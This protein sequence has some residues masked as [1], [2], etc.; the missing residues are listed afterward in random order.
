MRPSAARLHGK[1][2]VLALQ[3]GGALGAYQAGVY[4]VLAE[5]S[6][7]PDWVVGISIG[8]VN[9]AIIAGNP[10]EKRLSHL[11][12]FWERVSSGFDGQTLIPGDAARQVMDGWSAAAATLFG[13]SGFFAPRIP[14]PWWYLPGAPQ[15]MS[16]YDTTPLRE[17]L[18]E[19][20][21]FDRIN[22]GEMRFSVGAVNVR[23]G[24]F[25][26]FD[27][28]RDTIGPEHVMASGALPP[29]FP[30]VRIDGEFYW[31]GGVVT[32]TPLAYVLSSPARERENPLI[33]QVDLFSAIGQ[34]P[35][36]LPEVMERHKDILYSSRTRYITDTFRELHTLRW[37][38]Q[39]VL[40]KLPTELD[41]DPE[42]MR[43]KKLSTYYPVTV[44]HL[45]YRSKNFETQSKDYEFSRASMEEHWQAGVDDTHRTLRHPEWLAPTSDESGFET[46]DLTREGMV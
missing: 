34:L 32:N 24:N 33:F 31:D 16:I 27:N 26:Y 3:G 7:E 17:T 9:S 37:A 13:V 1:T 36:D 18:L 5:S 21:D 30:P 20:V 10:P 11:R 6:Y 12:A 39:R 22:S 4:Q 41:Q 43:L 19:L 8:A 14:P 15:A 46:L 45:I 28:R 2:I 42:I 29:G 25:V 44:V 35:R 40:A 23:T 38:A